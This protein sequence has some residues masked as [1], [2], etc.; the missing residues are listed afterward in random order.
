MPRGPA[1]SW[2]QRKQPVLDEWVL[3]SITRAN[4][5]PAADGHYAEMRIAKIGSRDEAREYIR[6]LH[7]SGRYLTRWSQY[8]IGVR[9]EIIKDGS[10]YLVRFWAV[11]KLAARK[12]ILEK[13]GPDR[14]K[15]PYDPRRRASNG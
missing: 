3:H 6:S 10:Q 5:K 12:Y 7:R 4:G 15:W 8:N 13:Y 2:R 9:A 14:S 1:P 11:D